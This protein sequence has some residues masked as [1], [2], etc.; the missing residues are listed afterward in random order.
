MSVLQAQLRAVARRHP[1]A[2]KLLVCPTLQ[3]ANDALDRLAREGTGWAAFRPATPE[4]L[5]ERL[6]GP[7]LEEEGWRDLSGVA[8]AFLL[9]EAWAERIAADASGYLSR[10]EPG[11][12]LFGAL[13]ETLDRLRRAGVSASDLDPE[14]FV[15]PRKGE[16]T[17]A[18]LAAY[19]DLLDER[20]LA[21][22]ATYLRRALRTLE[23]GEGRGV[24]GGPGERILLVPDEVR[25][26]PLEAE[27]L[28]RWPARERWRLGWDGDRGVEPGPSRAAR[29]L[30][31]LP[32]FEG[33][34]EAPR[35]AGWL[36]RARELPPDASGEVEV[37]LALGTENELRGLLREVAAGGASLDEVEI[38]YTDPERHPAVIRSEAARF[39]VECTFGG[40]LPLRVTRPGQALLH[41]LE[42]QADGFD[43][44]HLRRL[45][46]A[47][48]VDFRGPER[49]REVSLL[50]EQAAE[51]LREAQV[52]RGRGRYGPALERLRARA[53]R[54]EREAK[55]E[56]RWTEADRCRERVERIGELEG[57]LEELWQL[58]PHGPRAEVGAV[59]GGAVRFLEGWVPGRGET[60]AAAR[61][62]LLD[63]LSAVGEQVEEEA[64]VAEVLRYL[65]RSVREGKGA[66]SEPRPGRLH[67]VP[68][69]LG[70]YSGRRV[71]A[72][73]GL[74]EASFPGEGLEDPFLLDRERHGAAERIPSSRRAPAERAYDLA[75][76]LGEG[77]ERVLASASRWAVG[78]DRE[79][80]PSAAFLRLFRLAAGRS[81]AGFREC[82]EAL[83]PPEGPAPEAGRAA[84]AVEA[85]LAPEVRRGKDY[86]ERVTGR[87]PGVARGLEAERARSSPRFT[88]FDG[89]VP[90]GEGELDPRAEKALSAT[91]LETL[92]R[93]PH[94]YFLRYVL[95]LAPVEELE[96][97][98][99]RWL[100]PAERGR[101]L[102]GL[103]H[104]FM[105]EVGGRGERP[106]GERHLSLVRRIAEARAERT[107]AEIPPPTEAAYRREK[108][109]ILTTAEIFLRDEA[110]RAGEA[111]PWRHELRFGDP[112]AEG[113]EPPASASPV[114][115]S[116]PGVGALP[117][118]G[119]ID[120]VDRLG[121]GRFRIWDYKTGTASRY[122]RASAFEGGH[123]QWLLYALALEGLLAR[124][125]EGGEVVTSGY[126]F[127]GERAHGERIA[128][129][130][131]P[132]ARREL[133]RLLAGH[134]RLAQEGLF[135]HPTGRGRCRFCDFRR[136]CLDPERRQEEVRAALEAGASMPSVN[137]ALAAWADL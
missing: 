87:H 126:L 54:A 66:A 116:L 134:F 105:V 56:G 135:P 131:G 124:S 28:R 115:V 37:R 15:S 59:S 38:L 113:D 68:V 77:G 102:H 76:A 104:D 83:A 46:R 136:A 122:S 86:L 111:E 31:D 34:A 112:G 30:A 6:A 63:L 24:A 99:D 98:P 82:L 101:L 11:P 42:W 18:L 10:L 130:V 90:S 121:E 53:R 33:P 45:F 39:G 22:G 85:W 100:T 55:R 80:Y 23:G 118:R 9:R 110:D 79:L 57:L 40:G 41:F 51:L 132:E 88:V 47:G 137:A 70:G 60:E 62:A 8:R 74:D 84:A 44:R 7:A 1:A 35:K 127:P 117:L 73:V 89:R 27:L 61:S 107:R 13:G 26:S 36:F 50:P 93:S 114:E 58:A 20:K 128:H 2:E 125:G 129:R 94:R 108:A 133:G 91:R 69:A 103:F 71:T 16:E 25:L 21:D 19:E 97:E 64:P 48:L 109:A 43:D 12:G 14:A 96:A 106:D 119:S 92:V 5:A 78:E 72:V 29:R 3:A 65:E 120:R 32:R 49:E 75:R 67:A 4:Y 95:G 81:D 17:R 123:V 52:G